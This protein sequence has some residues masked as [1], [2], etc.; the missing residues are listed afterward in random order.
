[1]ARWHP[2]FWESTVT[3]VS[4]AE[5]RSGRYA[6]YEPDTLVGQAIAIGG[7]LARRI[8]AVE[9]RIR[10]L[11]GPG[12]HELMSVSRFLLRSEA[13]ASS[14]IEGVAPSA[15]Q[16]ALAELSLFPPQRDGHH[17]AGP[18]G[19][20]ST[21]RVPG[22]STQARLVA[23]NLTVVREAAGRLADSADV[24]AEDLADLH[25]A[26]LPDEPH[27]HGFRTG[28]NWIGGATHHPLG[29]DFVPPAPDEVLRLVADLLVYL[30]GAADSPLVQAAIV[31]AQF[32]TIHPFSDGNGRVG[33]AL[34]HT[35]LTRRGLT[36][37]AVLPIS[38]VLSTRRDDYMD[39]LTRYR[40]DGP[41]DSPQAQTA[42]HDWLVSCA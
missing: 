7:D 29:A 35:A 26:L 22:L 18:R 36:S 16:V 11:E 21:A 4:R 5:S 24:T 30:S 32:E 42:V 14:R 1:M 15:R 38:L 19:E 28:Q 20:Q 25:R 23:N 17:Q 41:R 12:A 33:R 8:G 6:W 37:A 9:R 3:G 2:A 40:Y 10:A 39:G 34:I 31:H 13:I 27:L